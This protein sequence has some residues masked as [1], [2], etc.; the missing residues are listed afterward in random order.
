MLNFQR[1]MFIELDFFLRESTAEHRI[2]NPE[3]ACDEMC[4]SEVRR[5][6]ISKRLRT[7][8]VLF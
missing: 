1:S 8:S 2:L 7:G 5:D 4:I 3:V 6:D